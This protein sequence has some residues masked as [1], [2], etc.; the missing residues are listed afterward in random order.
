MSVD[1]ILVIIIIIIFIGALISCLG[2]EYSYFPWFIHLGAWFSIVVILFIFIALI[3]LFVSFFVHDDKKSNNDNS[4]NDNSHKSGDNSNKKSNDFSHKEKN[5]KDE[6]CDDIPDKLKNEYDSDYFLAVGDHSDFKH[7]DIKFI[8]TK[9]EPSI[10]QVQTF[11]N[12]GY[13]LHPRHICS[14]KCPE[15]CTLNSS[16]QIVTLTLNG[17]E[18]KNNSSF[19]KVVNIVLPLKNPVK[20]PYKYM[21]N[22]LNN[23]S[24]NNDDDL[25]NISLSKSTVLYTWTTDSGTVI[26]Y[27]Y[28]IDGYFSL[29][30]IVPKNDIVSIG[31]F[32]IDS[33][34]DIR[35]GSIQ[36]SDMGALKNGKLQ[37]TTN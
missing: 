23:N 32:S 1:L 37:Y 18:G 21:Y 16:Q 36:M 13:D 4:N 34:Q 22:S 3:Y 9:N 17:V 28:I 11:T 26:T 8:S 33:L 15:N 27:N 14:K 6:K 31:K 29:I 35:I 2:K 24:S 25:S 10:I 30:T 19:S 5:K 12:K 20:S 7:K